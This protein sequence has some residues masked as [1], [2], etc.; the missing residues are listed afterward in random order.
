MSRFDVR[1]GGSL[2]A[3][4]PQDLRAEQPVRSLDEVVLQYLRDASTV[5]PVD[6]ERDDGEYGVA[7]LAHLRVGEQGVSRAPSVLNR[8][9]QQGPHHVTEGNPAARSEWT[10]S[11]R[12]LCRFATNHDGLS[13]RVACLLKAVSI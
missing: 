9:R 2:T 12:F 4:V 11:A 8:K 13:V 3:A 6:T 5:A 1:D 10:R 7:H